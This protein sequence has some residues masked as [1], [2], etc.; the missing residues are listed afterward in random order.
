MDWICVTKIERLCFKP[1]PI[2]ME[3]VSLT[4]L[5]V[6]GAIIIALVGF[7]LDLQNRK[8]DRVNRAWSLVAAAKEV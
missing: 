4:E 1:P 2:V 8:E 5:I 7:V 6:A 3:R